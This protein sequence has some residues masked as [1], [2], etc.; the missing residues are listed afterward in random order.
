MID[1]PVH[2]TDS[3]F[4]KTI[5][6]SNLPVIVDFWA[7][8]C[9]PCRMV[10]PTLDKL[11]KENAGTLLVTKVNTDNIYVSHIASNSNWWTGLALLNTTDAEKNMTITF[12]DGSV[13]LLSLPAG[14]HWSGTVSDLSGINAATIESA[15][16]SNAGGIIGLEV[17]GSNAGTGDQYL[18]GV[19]LSGKTTLSL[20]Y[21]HVVS[22]DAWWTGIVVYNPNNTST[23]LTISPYD[24]E[25][26]PLTTSTENITAGGKFIGTVADLSLPERT[27]WFKVDASAPITGFELFG[28]SNGNQLAGFNT[29]DISTTAGT[30]VKMDDN[31]W[32][33]IAFVNIEST[34]ATVTLTAF[35]NT[36]STV[37]V[38]TFTVPGNG[39]KI[40]LPE[41]LFS[42]DISG[43]TYLKFTSTRNVVGFQVNGSSDGLMLDGLPSLAQSL[44]E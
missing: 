3:A 15:V 29:T 37:A 16:I 24:G 4:E 25:G 18:S 36:G 6:Q 28:T 30:F 11:A 26:T 27:R 1:E 13:S 10:A 20:Y 22:N 38:T 7:P 5:L 21:P 31:G 2:V 44:D 8:W 12:N 42:T 40:G 19:L 14:E 9:G 17:F 34:P 23:T 33:G 35:N 32:T 39:K 43:A 41:N